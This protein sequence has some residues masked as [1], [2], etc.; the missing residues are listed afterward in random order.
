MPPR[1]RVAQK[2]QGALFADRE[3]VSFFL[4]ASISPRAGYASGGGFFLGRR[5]IPFFKSGT[6]PFF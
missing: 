3:F 5:P 4:I 1:V 6:F 2:K